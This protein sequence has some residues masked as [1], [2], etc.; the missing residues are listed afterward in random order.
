MSTNSPVIFVI[1]L[2]PPSITSG[3]SAWMNAFGI[4]HVITLRP[5]CALITAVSIMLSSAAVG[6]AESSLDSQSMDGFPV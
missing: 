6:L 3:I 5:S 4:S 2:M 1:T